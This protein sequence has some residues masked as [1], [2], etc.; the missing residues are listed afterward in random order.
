MNEKELEIVK[1]KDKSNIGTNSLIKIYKDGMLHKEFVGIVKGEI[2]GDGLITLADMSKFYNYYQK[3]ITMNKYFE[4][5]AD[6]NGDSKFSL[7]DLSKFYNYYQ[8][9]INKL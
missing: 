8:G 7:A 5:A 3:N 6:V 1:Q 9:K 4:L 2:T